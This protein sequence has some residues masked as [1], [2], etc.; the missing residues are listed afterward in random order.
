MSLLAI[1]L[2]AGAGLTLLCSGYLFGARRGLLAREALRQKLAEQAQTE[3]TLRQQVARLEQGGQKQLSESLGALLEPLRAQEQKNE[4]A[5]RAMLKLVRPVVEKD[6][7]SQGLQQLPQ[8][9][10]S[11]SGLRELLDRLAERGGF[12]AV[13][14][15]DEAGLPMACNHSCTS[16]ETLAGTSSLLL[17]LAERVPRHGAARPHSFVLHD[18]AGQVTLH[19]IFSVGSQRYLLSVVSNSA[20]DF[21]QPELFDTPI[22]RLRTLLSS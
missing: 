7:L 22:A 15:S 4:E 16:A 17:I 1:T 12:A 21:V 10:D 2:A 5:M 6:R 18:E 19:R 20:P 3:S 13:V 9:S 8:L 14:L 11:R